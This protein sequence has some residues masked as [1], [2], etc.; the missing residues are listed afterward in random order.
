MK[1]ITL[2]LFFL[3]VITNACLAE[4]R[5]YATGYSANSYINTFGFTNSSIANSAANTGSN[6]AMQAQN[7]LNAFR[8]SIKQQ[9][10]LPPLQ[11]PQVSRI[12]PYFSTGQC[13]QNLNT[14]LDYSDRLKRAENEA[15]KYDYLRN[16]P[17]GTSYLDSEGLKSIPTQGIVSPHSQEKY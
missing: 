15:L 12:N 4:D 7:N 5:G 13:T 14:Y 11:Q 17:S 1:R 6:A 8:N 2:I 3:W 10:S 16:N 9:T